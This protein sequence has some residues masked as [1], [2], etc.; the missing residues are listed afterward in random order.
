MKKIFFS[1]LAIG[2]LASCAK[3]DAVYE[4]VQSE[5]KLAPVAAL[6]TKANVLAAIDGTEY[7]T[8]ENFDVYGYWKNVGAGEIYT[9]GASYFGEEGVEFVNKGNYWGGAK[10]Y[11]WPK[12]GAL[13]FAAYSPADLDLA[14][15]QVGDVFSVDGYVQPSNTAETWDFLVAPTSE[16]YTAMTA[17]ENVSI[18]FKHAL[19]WITLKV[20]AKDAEAAEVF[21]IKNVT[22]NDVNTTAYFEASMLDGIQNEEWKNLGTPAEYVV[23]D[24]E[25]GVTGEAAVIETTTAGTLVIPQ[26]TTNVT[27]VFDQK[28][29]NGT[30]DMTNME[31]TLDLVLDQD[32]EPWKPGYHYTYTLIF[33][34]DEILINPSVEDWTEY[35]W[36]ADG[37]QGEI[38][39]EEPVSNVATA[40]QL[41]DALAN[42]G[43][44]VL[45]NN[46]E[47]TETVTVPAGVTAVLDLNGKNI[48]NTPAGVATDVIIVKGELT[49]NGE[50]SVEAADGTDGYTVISEGLLIINGGEYKAGADENGEANAVIYARGNGK[51]FVN[52]GTFPNDA[53]SV[54]VLNKKDADRATTEISVAGG[55]FKNFNPGDNAA[56]NPKESFLKEGF[57]VAVDGEWYNVLLTNV[58][59]ADQLSA[60]LASNA[61]VKLINDI[62]MSGVEWTPVGTAE[63]NWTGVLDGQGH[64]ITGLELT[65]DY[66][67]F[68]AYAGEDAVIKNVAFED[69]NIESTKYGAAVIC[70][71]ENNVTVENVTV[72]GSV[73]ATSYA[74]GLVLMNNDDDDV[75][76]IKNCENNATVTSSRAG[77]IA[78][79]VTGGSVLENVVNNGDITGEISACGIT[80]RIAGTIKNAVNNGNITGNGSEASAG[81]AGTQT[82][83][84]TFEYCYN[85]GNV[86]TTKDNANASAAGIL[87]QTPSKAATLNYCANFGAITAE[88][89]YAAGIAYSLYGNIKASYCYNEGAINGADGAGAIA[90]KAQYGAN[91]TANYC[92]N[93]GTV[94]SANGKVYQ[95]SNKNNSSYYYSNGALL[96]VS[97]NAAVA[98]AD[99]LVVL[100]GGADADFFALEGGVIVVK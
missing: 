16:S 61:E 54:Y 80:N 55:S 24:G 93:A 17:A 48:V 74:A 33:G 69:V 51:V 47:L 52:G 38:T 57:G 36:N 72:S 79:W 7:P 10:T 87:G 32:D 9:D 14:H 25:Q 6:Q 29:V 75:V 46:I 63:E 95:G 21:T 56:E 82:A 84:S 85:Y 22:I 71:A 81:I 77:G 64:K 5:I 34:L 49:I 100:N 92:L 94:A 3:T 99:A 13:R 15:E 53:N 60:A 59:N 90:P 83:A 1:F 2:A 40:E 70:V 50:G 86:T 20:K 8:A 39:T 44:V 89:S 23:F 65:G 97:N 67:A 11:Y 88:Q 91:D 12:N 43:K 66:A 62:D 27:V 78:A 18:V 45:Q 73:K 76:F 4:D 19:S 68:V 28:G 42:G 98:E 30:L 37:T 26:A 96:N 31:V 35:V 58:A 41:A